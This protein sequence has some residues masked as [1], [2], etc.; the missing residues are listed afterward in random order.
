MSFFDALI[1]VTLLIPIAL[2]MEHDA[3]W[4]LFTASTVGKS[5]TSTSSAWA[6]ILLGS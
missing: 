1:S 2:I 5:G 6:L 3:I 4:D